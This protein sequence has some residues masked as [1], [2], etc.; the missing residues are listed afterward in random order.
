MTGGESRHLDTRPPSVPQDVPSSSRIVLAIE[1][2][3]ARLEQHFADLHARRRLISRPLFALEH[4]LAK[5]ELEALAQCVRRQII[6]RRPSCRLAWIVYAAELGYRYVGDEYWYTFEQE[7]PGWNLRGERSWIRE[8]FQWF[9][10]T[11]GGARPSGPW[12]EHFSIICWPITHALLPLDLQRQLAR[13][14]YEWRHTFS[15]D[16]FE[17]PAALGN[18]IASRSWTATSRFQNLAEEPEF[19]GQIA[20]ALLLKG[21]AGADG[22]IHPL[23]LNRISTDLEKET[24]AREWLHDAR[25]SAQDRFRVQGLSFG[26]GA[27]SS[28][29]A[30]TAKPEEVR[31]EVSLLGIEPRAVLRPTDLARSVWEVL[32][33]IPDLSA[34]SVRFPGSRDTLL[35]SRCTV[36]GAAG[37]PLARGQVLHGAQKVLLARWPTANEPLLTFDR[38]DPLLSMLLRT[39]GLL[40]PG[41]LRLFRIASDGL[42]Y[43]TRSPI[44][45]AGAKYILT[46]TTGSPPTTSIGM[47]PVTL[48]C[49]GVSA[50]TFAV[51][52]EI[53]RDWEHALHLVGLK[54]SKKLEVWPAGLSASSWDGEGHGEWL[55]S[56]RPCLGIRADHD[57]AALRIAIAGSAASSLELSDISTGETLFVEL[58]QLAVGVHPINFWSRK[59]TTDA[60]HPLG[61]LDVVVRIRE[62]RSWVAGSAQSSPLRVQVDPPVPTLEQLWEGRTAVSIDGPNGRSVRCAITLCSEGRTLVNG[63]LQSMP[64]PVAPDTWRRQFDHYLRQAPGVHAAYDLA[65]SAEITFSTDDLGSVSLQCDRRFAPL[66]WTVRKVGGELTAQ[67]RNDTGNETAPSVSFYPCSNPGSAAALALEAVYRVPRAGGLFVAKDV[68]AEASVLVSPM[69]DGASLNELHCTPTIS[70]LPIVGTGGLLSIATLWDSATPAGGVFASIRQRDTLLAI[71]RRLTRLL[72]G[73]AWVDQ[74]IAFENGTSTASHLRRAIWQNRHDADFATRVAQSIDQMALMTCTERAVMLANVAESW[75]QFDSPGDSTR[76]CELALR[77]FTDPGS[78][79]N[80]A[81]SSLEAGVKFLQC[82]PVLARAARFVVATTARGAH[83]QTAGREIYAS[84]GWE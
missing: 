1:A 29:V 35:N 69:L 9:H 45:R 82:Q 41:S 56:E 36:T 27:T 14:L 61:D 6:T 26:R 52:K 46:Q 78:V 74:E 37:R 7:T 55:A 73:P 40:R 32:L 47:T 71:A 62:S 53:P 59:G 66:R 64:L 79:Q 11:Y 77:V 75:L 58:P 33:E 81:G 13:I 23:T 20:M 49:N 43:E 34:V 42:A 51:P 25:Q 63:R 84:W 19:I 5:E 65:T 72:C 8:S 21:D 17:S 16:L 50:V 2:W 18:F 30:P 83:S 68:K 44:V 70:E 54:L 48:K 12:A 31:K 3:Q 28:R 4:G 39:S 76:V 60:W 80:W 15:E 67:L 22:L 57:L 24:R 10:S 38:E